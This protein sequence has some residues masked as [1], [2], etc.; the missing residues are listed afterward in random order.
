MRLVWPSQLIRLVKL[1]IR[2]VK[3][4]EIHLGPASYGFIALCLCECRKSKHYW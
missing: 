2:G 1:I 3:H 4:E